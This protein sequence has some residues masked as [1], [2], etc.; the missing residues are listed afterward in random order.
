MPRC[1]IQVWLNG[2]E[3]GISLLTRLCREKSGKTCALSYS[4]GCLAIVIMT[5]EAEEL[6]HDNMI[7]HSR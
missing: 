7:L 4:M 6:F 3:F 2:D 1:A 5:I